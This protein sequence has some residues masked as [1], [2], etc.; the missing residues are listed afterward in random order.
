MTRNHARRNHYDRVKDSRP[1]YHLLTSNVVAKVLFRSKQAIGVSY[2]PTTADSTAAPS[3]VYA[4]K[5]VILTAGGFG[6]PKILQLSGV[7]PK[8]LLQKFGISVVS[9]LPGV[10]QN[11]QDQPTLSVPYTCKLN[12]LVDC[13]FHLPRS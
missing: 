12:R 8:K 6:T 10:G 4:T 3:N 5:E 11:L 2:L 7:G 13:L 1:N 9:D